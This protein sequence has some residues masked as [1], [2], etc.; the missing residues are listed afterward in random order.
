[1]QLEAIGADAV[2]M[3]KE[4][5]KANYLECRFYAASA[6]AYL[7][8]SAGLETLYEAARDEPAF[9]VFAL[10]AMSAIDEGET[11]LYL[12][13]LM[14]N[15]L[16][17]TRYGAFRC[18]TTIDE[19]EPFVVGESLN[20]QCKL[21]V[22][23]VPGDPMIHLTHRQKSEIVLFG[24]NQRFRTPLALNAGPHIMV[25]AAPGANEVV[26]SRYRI[27]EDDQREVVSDRIDDVLRAAARMGASYPDLAQLL[28]Q[29]ERQQNLP[30]QIGID[31]LPEAGRYYQRPS[32][33][34]AAGDVQPG[35]K[36]KIGRS[37]MTPNPFSKGGGLDDD[38]TKPLLTPDLE[39]EAEPADETQSP[40]ETVADKPAANNASLGPPPSQGGR[41]AASSGPPA[42]GNAAS[43]FE[44]FNPKKLLKR[45]F[46]P[47]TN[48][49]LL[50]PEV[51]Q[52]DE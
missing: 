6:L 38:E 15:T 33:P 29:A 13:Q 26:V 48:G 30:G 10:A 32:D 34:S 42:Q 1:L 11:H 49:E 45:A 31:M 25:N 24:S 51:N 14:D 50:Y 17:E 16:L 36:K 20:D 4:G 2:P 22:L 41:A 40:E 46:T 37:A 44:T 35:R 28:V 27:G 43:R 23:D 9:R 8:E 18:M 47:P 5:L 3:L 52:T 12:R 7:G 21:H 19:R 39:T